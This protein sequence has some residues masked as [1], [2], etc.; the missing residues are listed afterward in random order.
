MVA[1]STGFNPT[2][3]AQVD[4]AVSD[5]T[6]PIT[7]LSSDV[8]GDLIG[9]IGISGG[10][11]VTVTP[12]MVTSYRS[13]TGHLGAASA[14]SATQMLS[15]ARPNAG[16]DDALE[17]PVSL[18]G[19][20]RYAP[21]L[22]FGARFDV[23]VFGIRVV[24]WELFAVPMTL[25]ALERAVAMTSETP[26]HFALPVL[27]G[28]GEG[29]R[30]DF[31]SGPTQVL[32]IRNRGE[33]ALTIDPA[34]VPPGISVEAINIAPGAS[35]ELRVTASDAAFSEGS[36]TLLLATSD[37]DHAQLSIEL[38]REVGGTDPGMVEEPAEA[39]GCSTSGG[40][41]SLVIGLA[42]LLLVRRRR[43]F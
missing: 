4:A 36:K 16:F 42:M 37:P 20:V 1:G 8:I 24:D 39:G 7:V 25:P 23:K 14:T 35:A 38:G 40:T 28:V 27:D 11:R 13:T 15:I 12:S 29:A 30:I 17:L 2:L 22:T 31:A 33:L 32:A 10:L 34:S 26:A 21:T 5:G 41:G 43:T 18:D 3:D 6:A 19:V 9:I